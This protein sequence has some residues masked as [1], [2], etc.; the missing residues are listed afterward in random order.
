MHEHELQNCP[1]EGNDEEKLDNISR[2]TSGGAPIII[3]HIRA[4][5]SA[6]SQNL[7][8]LVARMRRCVRVI[9]STREY[10]GTY[11]YLACTSC[12]APRFLALGQQVF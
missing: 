11:S 2:V 12:E 9:L 5:P 7:S 4:K 6:L 3:K 1:P 10:E 8:Q